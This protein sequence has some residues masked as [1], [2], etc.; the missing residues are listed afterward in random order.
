MSFLFQY[1]FT[2]AIIGVVFLALPSM[3]A[4]AT[5]LWGYIADRLVIH[6]GSYRF[7]ILYFMIYFVETISIVYLYHNY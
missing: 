4:I 7:H 1:Q 6:Q 2:P 5:P 3:Y